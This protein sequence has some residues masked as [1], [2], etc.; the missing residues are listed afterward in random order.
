VIRDPNQQ[1]VL[2]GFAITEENTMSEYDAEEVIVETTAID[3]DGDGQ[4]D[5]VEVEVTEEL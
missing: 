3:I 1:S 4:A 2:G 5:V